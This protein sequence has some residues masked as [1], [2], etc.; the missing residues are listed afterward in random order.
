MRGVS[1]E[2]RQYPRFPFILDIDMQKIALVSSPREPVQTVHGRLQN[3]SRGGL[4]VLA[5]EPMNGVRAVLCEIFVPA[6]SVPIP[7]LANVRWS[8]PCHSSNGGRIYGLQFL[9]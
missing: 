4:C 5:D 1:Q 6:L 9:Y 2:C 3:L 7:V 8:E